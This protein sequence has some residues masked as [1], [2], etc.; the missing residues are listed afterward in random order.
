MADIDT[1]VAVDLHPDTFLS[2]PGVDDSTAPFIAPAVEAFDAAYKYIGSI[3]E[4]REAAF[5]DPTLTQE[6]ALLK[7]DDFA[8]QRLATVTKKIDG[9]VAQL[10]K[11]I[12][13][14]QAEMSANVKAQ[15]SSQVS[16]EVRSLMKASGDRV[17][18][19][20]QA[21]ADGE[22]DILTAVLGGPAVLSGLSK[23]MHAGF[24]R[25]YHE[26]KNPER[27][28]RLKAMIAAR[29]RL[30]Q[31]GGLVLKEMVKAVGVILREVRDNNGN[32]KGH[33][34]QGPDVI[35]AKRDKS[36]AVYARHS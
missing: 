20:E 30:E 6:G 34:P 33:R 25:Q 2:L 13:S 15:A 17:K 7:A 23:E 22:D 5:A 16:G 28:Q 9:A 27:A 1:H 29:T 36:A 21:F 32:M 31:R 8:K 4:V 11:T 35:R 12:D 10:T 3:Y 19:I 26:M 18:M 24:L 14:Y